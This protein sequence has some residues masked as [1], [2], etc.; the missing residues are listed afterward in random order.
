M[1]STTATTWIEIGLVIS[2]APTPADP[3]VGIFS[4]GWED[5]TIEELRYE[6]KNYR[7]GRTISVDLLDGVD[8]NNPEVQKILANLLKAVGQDSV[9]EAL[10]EELN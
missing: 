2:A 4:A 10:N 6:E 8:S 9:W 3:D 1:T 7:T 5:E